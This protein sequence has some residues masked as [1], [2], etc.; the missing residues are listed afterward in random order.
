MPYQLGPLLR[1]DVIL[2]F[3]G[4]LLI[5]HPAWV[6]PSLSRMW[7]DFTEEE[8]GYPALVKVL[9]ML[10]NAGETPQVIDSDDLRRDPEAVVG[11]WCDSV[12]IER[13]PDALNWEPGMPEDWHVWGPWFTK[14][15]QS[16][17]FLPPSTEEPPLVDERLA[18]RIDALRPLYS[19]LE[20]YKLTNA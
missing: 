17:C 1:P 7:D 4:S 13:R 3:S 11:K 6:V 12:G 16:T 18:R 15:S 10:R 9:A 19:H 14:A 2:S 20:S 8:S 5:R